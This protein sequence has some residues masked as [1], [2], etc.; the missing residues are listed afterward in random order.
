M[1]P[2]FKLGVLAGVAGSVATA[3]AAAFGYRQTVIKPQ[4]EAEE[5]YV[6]TAKATAR[7][8]VSAHQSRF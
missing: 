4:Q 6:E 2:T 1:K 5:T 7:K 3:L 8:R